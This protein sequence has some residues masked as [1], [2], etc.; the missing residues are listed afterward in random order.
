[1][2]RSD[3]S[4]FHVFMP[5]VQTADHEGA[6][7]FAFGMYWLTFG[8]ILCGWVLLRLMGAEREAQM[9]AMRQLMENEKQ[10]QPGREP[11]GPADISTASPPAATG[12]APVSTPGAV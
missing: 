7:P 8:A 4:S 3:R 11:S 9:R 12:Q 5:M 2:L 1:M 10:L 6:K